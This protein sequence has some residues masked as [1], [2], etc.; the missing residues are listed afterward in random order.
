M[1]ELEKWKALLYKV[2]YV[3]AVFIDLSKVFFDP[4]KNS[5]LDIAKITAYDF[6]HKSLDLMLSYM[7]NRS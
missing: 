5:N 4:P 1:Y 7:K 3:G 6:S 2:D